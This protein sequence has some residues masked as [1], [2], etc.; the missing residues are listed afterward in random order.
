MFQIDQVIYFN[1]WSLFILIAFATSLEYIFE[2][3]LIL[4]ETYLKRKIVFSTFRIW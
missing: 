3:L 1:Y 4:R 2:E